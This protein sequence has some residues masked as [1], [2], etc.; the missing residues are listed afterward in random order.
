MARNRAS[1]SRSPVQRTRHERWIWGSA[2]AILLAALAG[3]YFRTSP[4]P[5]Q[6]TWSNILAPENTTLAYF[7][8][9]V[10][11]SHDGRSLAFVATVPGGQ[12]MLWVRPL[13]GL[14]AQELAGTDGAS[15]PFWSP[16]DRSIGFFSRGKLK[17]IDASGGPVLM[18]CD[19]AARRHMESE[20]HHL[21]F[22]NLGCCPAGS[23][24]WRQSHPD[25]RKS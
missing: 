16:D 13:A 12:D 2:V 6:P 24:L 11:V 7:A 3:L 22:R 19:A 8:G 25:R 9:P 15:N 21:V 23:K 10:T 5:T 20:R 17:T 14:K 1:Q 18:V 4:K